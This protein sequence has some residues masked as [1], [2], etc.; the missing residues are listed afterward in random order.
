[1]TDSLYR[2]E[3]LDHQSRKLFGDVILKSPP[4]IWGVA[5]MLIILGGVILLMLFGLNIQTDQGAVSLW[6]WMRQGRS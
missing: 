6:E 4:A 2:Q 1:M 3:A 5:L